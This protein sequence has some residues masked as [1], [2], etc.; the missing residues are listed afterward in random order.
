MP[1]NRIFR[2]NVFSVV[3]AA[4]LGW[5]TP[6]T[7]Q[8]ASNPVEMGVFPYLSTRAL[9]DLYEPVR[10]LL[11]AE[12]NRP[13]HLFTATSFKNYVDRTQAGEYDV[14]VT[15]PHM[16]RLAQREAGY[17]PLTI[18][19]REL[20][21]VVVVAKTSAIQT[22]QDLKGKRIATPN[23]VALVA[24]M[25]SQL[26][27]DKGLGNDVYT[28]IRDVGSHSNAVLAVQRKEA[29]AAIT[30]YVALQQMPEDLRN[31]VR[32][33]AQTQRLPH[34]M[35]LAH[36][37][38]GQA[39]VEQVRNLL[40]RFPNT[41]EGRAFLKISGYEGIRTVEEADMKSVDPFIKELKRLLEA[42]PP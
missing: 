31:S 42:M 32:I 13:T 33:I 18:F 26:L 7:A 39:G 15:P 25:G 35:F 22:V 19:T 24:I 11:Q 1:G 34:V 4:M 2:L 37:R 41:A 9:L 20:R 6:V 38:L 16:A 23:K 3:L 36:P 40:L 30:E 10:V 5:T 12:L 21:G 27:R 28:L 29:E 8:N 14:V 17:I